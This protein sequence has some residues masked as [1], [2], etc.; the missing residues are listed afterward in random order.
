MQ[1]KK[2][3]LEQYAPTAPP[4]APQNKFKPKDSLPFLS[5]VQPMFAALV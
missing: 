1:T 3:G 5:R 4:A 2:N